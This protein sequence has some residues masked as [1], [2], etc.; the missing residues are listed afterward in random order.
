MK[1]VS[2]IIPAYN[3]EK[4]IVG[5]LDSICQQ[6]YE[7]LEILVIDD[8]SIDQTAILL[9]KYAEK[10]GRIRPFYNTNHGVSYT[11]NFA[12]DRCKGDY[13]A[14]VDA[15]DL[16]APDFIAQMVYDLEKVDADMAAVAVQKSSILSKA[17]FTKGQSIIFENDEIL[18]QLFGAYEG[19][20][21]NKLYKKSLLQRNHIYLEHGIAVC[22]DL[23][24]NAEYLLHCKKVIYNNGKKYFYRQDINSASNRLDNPKWFEA[25]KAYQR[26]LK[27]LYP[28]SKAYYRAAFGYAMFLCAA[29][30]RLSVITD[31]SGD[32]R[33]Q[34]AVEWRK[35]RPLWSSFSWK[36]QLKLH[37]FSLCPGIV[38][39]YQRRKL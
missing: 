15:D 22:E 3:A 29:K 10:D 37:I 39:R 26:V 27:L 4:Y 25:R 5:C 19:F 23:L 2:V 21:W 11:R 12:L 16:V 9:R 20:L 30:Y 38:V 8:G 24:F 32:L 31:V 33:E 28:Y 17:E 18:V 7:N 35:I 6:T 36:Q 34:V 13:V 14:F 1:R